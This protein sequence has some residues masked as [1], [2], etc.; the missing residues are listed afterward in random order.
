MNLV[1]ARTVE[2]E[3]G[4]R[5]IGIITL[6]ET[7]SW[8]MLGENAIVPYEQLM[9]IEQH[10]EQVR[11]MIHRWLSKRLVIEALFPVIFF[12][13]PGTRETKPDK[14]NLE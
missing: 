11:W 2:T 8:Q 12:T 10:D 7:R 4:S 1:Y 6:F 14:S 5:C 9:I 13:L 3:A